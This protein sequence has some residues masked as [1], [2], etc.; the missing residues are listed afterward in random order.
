MNKI[1]PGTEH[2]VRRFMGLIPARFGMNRVFNR[3]WP[4]YFFCK[5]Q[6]AWNL[7]AS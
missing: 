2:A 7:P 3:A 1:D 6:T 5:S 4:L